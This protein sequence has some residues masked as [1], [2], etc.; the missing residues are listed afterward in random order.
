MFKGFKNFAD[1]SE[2]AQI[3]FVVFLF[4]LSVHLEI[5][6]KVCFEMLHYDII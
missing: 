3:Y 6:H 2:V 5:L 1:E 4:H